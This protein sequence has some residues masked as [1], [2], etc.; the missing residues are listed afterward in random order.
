MPG[1]QEVSDELLEDIDCHVIRREVTGVGA[2]E[3]PG[4]SGPDLF[5][6]EWM[7]QTRTAPGGGHRQLPEEAEL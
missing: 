6:Q 1:S 3:D 2:V 4:H 5:V 7:M